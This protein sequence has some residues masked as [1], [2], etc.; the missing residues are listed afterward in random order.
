MTDRA[1]PD[2]KPQPGLARQA[3]TSA[4]GA[5]RA[6]VLLYGLLRTFQTTA[7]S[8]L[9]HVVVPNDADLFYFGPE[10]SDNPTAAH[11]GVLDVFGNFKF[12]PKRQLDPMRPVDATVVRAAYGAHLRDLRLHRVAMDVFEAECPL[13][14]PDEWIYGLNPARLYSMFYNMKGAAE[15]LA[16][17]ERRSGVTYDHVI[18]TRPDIAF[19]S[20]V[21]ACA[22]PGEVH[23]PNGE[24][25]DARGGK[26]RGNA[27]VLYYRD[28]ETG[29]FL[30]G[31]DRI[32]FNDQLFVLARQHL[33]CFGEV[34]PLLSEYLARR[35]PPS[36]ET[37]LYLHLV[38][39]AGLK[40]V[41][42]DEW[43]Y[44]LYREGM[45]VQENVLDTGML[46]QIDRRHPRARAWRRAHPLRAALRDVKFIL[47]KLLQ[48][49]RR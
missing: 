4:P 10:G 27:R 31:N 41:K 6:A 16:E 7:P 3:R 45:R 36:P 30:E 17:H 39:R 29:D 42:H 43:C 21:P 49:L 40:P 9:R 35:V 24:G 15:L 5:G 47:R 37:I 18:L 33:A 19:F 44:M 34:Y 38:A 13:K 32:K 23:I 48:R 14:G 20:P 26:H 8:L 12:N 25:I 22:R 11:D 1:I 2:V 28:I 46:V